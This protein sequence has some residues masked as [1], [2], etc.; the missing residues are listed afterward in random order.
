M[1]VQGKERCSIHRIANIRGPETKQ[2]V[3][4]ILIHSLHSERIEKIPV[5]L[6]K[7]RISGSQGITLR[8]VLVLSM[9]L[10][11]KDACANG[12]THKGLTSLMHGLL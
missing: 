12:T 6:F 4:T 3:I 2:N 1:T 9:L 8:A 5:Y 10:R 7:T 11:T